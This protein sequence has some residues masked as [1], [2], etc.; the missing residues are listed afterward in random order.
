MKNAIF[1][2][3][4]PYIYILCKPTFRRNVSPPSSEYKNPQA[5]NP[6]EQVT[7]AKRPDVV[8]SR[9]LGPHAG[10]MSWSVYRHPLQNRIE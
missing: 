7:A 6:R 4:A 8:A 9:T 10:C 2:N 3:V 1:W 5:G